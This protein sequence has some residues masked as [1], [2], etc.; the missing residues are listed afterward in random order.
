MCIVQI[1]ERAD[2]RA[3]SP[4]FVSFQRLN[5]NISL[6]RTLGVGASA[7]TI[8]VYAIMA[9]VAPLDVRPVLFGTLGA[10]FG[11]A[12]VIGPLVG[13]I[14]YPHIVPRGVLTCVVRRVHGPCIMAMVL[15]RMLRS[16]LYLSECLHCYRSTYQ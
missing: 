14:S 3:I 11:L 6:H 9:E 13:G 4:R 7:G 15:L 16:N 1:H 5:L 2:I 8:S 12:A 10:T